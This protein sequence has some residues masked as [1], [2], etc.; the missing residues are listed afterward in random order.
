M[1]HVYKKL[2]VVGTSKT[3]IEDA[4]S[5]ALLKATAWEGTMRWFEITEVRG[6]IENG[7]VSY[8]QVGLKIGYSMGELPSSR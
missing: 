6:Y 1:E 3:G 4:I 2:E 5:D 7:S 8:Y